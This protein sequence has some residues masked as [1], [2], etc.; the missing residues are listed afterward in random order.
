[1]ENVHLAQI[2]LSSLQIYQLF[3]LWN[4]ISLTMLDYRCCF[5]WARNSDG[6]GLPQ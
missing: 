5:P 3:V 4:G 1:M 2:R 6:L